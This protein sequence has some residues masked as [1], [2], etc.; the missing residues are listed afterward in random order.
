MQ[1][2]A[3]ARDG[4]DALERGE[5]VYVPGRANRMIKTLTKLMPDRMA[6]RIVQK[7]SKDFRKV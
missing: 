2:D 7:R 3:V 1:A 5:V 4:I 6:L